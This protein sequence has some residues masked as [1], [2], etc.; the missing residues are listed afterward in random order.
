MMNIVPSECCG[1]HEDNTMCCCE[2]SLEIINGEM[3]VTH[4]T[5]RLKTEEG[6]GKRS[7]GH[8]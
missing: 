3:L 8:E 5:L 2:P 1:I 6:C 7:R 4:K